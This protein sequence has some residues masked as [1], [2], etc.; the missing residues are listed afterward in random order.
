MKT[1]LSINDLSVNY[2]QLQVVENL[3]FDVADNKITSLIGPN[4]CGKSTAIKAIAGITSYSGKIIASKKI[5]YL[6][7]KGS[8]MPWL[9]V[10]DNI[11]LPAKLKELDLT[12][13]K[14]SCEKYLHDFGLNEFSDYYPHQLSGGMCQ[15]VALIRTVLYQPDLVLIDEP[16]SALDA[17][18]RLQM[19]DWFLKLTQREKFAC[20]LVTHDINEAIALSDTIFALSRRPAKI[21]EEFKITSALRQDPYKKSQLENNLKRILLN[22]KI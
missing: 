2:D 17:I 1:P 19:Q 13:A 7:Q 9:S 12:K 16:F 6:P 22:E 20:L 18:T 8:L 21:V 15:K 14:K 5:A 11:L 10:T 4:G 3:R